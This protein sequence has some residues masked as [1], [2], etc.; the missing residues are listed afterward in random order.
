VPGEG[1]GL[2]FAFAAFAPAMLDRALDVYRAQFRPSP[3]LAQPYVMLGVN[4][5]AADSEGEPLAASS[6][7]L[8]A[9]ARTS[10]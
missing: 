2:P 4:V 5:L 10:S 7:S 8:R 6:R 1:L 9:R 3:E